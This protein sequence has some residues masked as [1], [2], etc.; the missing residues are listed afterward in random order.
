MVLNLAQCSHGKEGIDYSFPKT[1]DVDY[2]YSK[3]M[4]TFRMGFQWERM[5][6]TLMGEFDQTYFNKLDAV[7]KYANSKNMNVFLNPHNFARY[8][9]NGIEQLVGSAL[10]P[11]AAFAD[12]W[13]RLS[14]KYKD[15]PLVMFS[16]VNE[17]HDM[18]TMQ[19][20]SAANDAIAAIRSTGAKN[21]I[22]VPGNAWTGANQWSSN[23][24][25]NSG[26]DVAN[27]VAMLN[28]KDSQNNYVF[29]VHNY[30]DD[31]GSGNYKNGDCL[32]A[33]AGSKKLENVTAWARTNK[34]KVLVGEFA[35]LDTPTCKSAVDDFLKY[36]T[37]NPDVY[38]GWLWWSAGSSWSSTYKLSLNQKNGVDDPRMSFMTSYLPKVE[39]KDSSVSDASVP[40]SAPPAPT[41]LTTTYDSN[42]FFR[43][44]SGQ[45]P[46]IG[47]KP[48]TY[49]D[50]NPISL[51]VWMHGC[52]GNAE[53]DLWSVAPSATKKTQSYIV[54][55]LG[56]RD[57]ACWKVNED[58]PK[59]LAAIDHVKKYFNIN[60]RKIY[61]GGYSSGGDMTYRVGM[62]N[63]NLFAGLFVENSDIWGA[64]VAQTTLMQQAAWKLNI[65]QLN[66]LSDTTYPIAKSRTNLL[67]LKNAGFQ[68]IAV[69]K[70]GTHFDADTA[71]SG[72]KYNLIKYVLP[73]L[74]AEWM[75]PALDAGAPMDAAV[76][77]SSASVDASLDSGSKDA[78]V[79]ASDAGKDSG[80]FDSGIKD[81]GTD[82]SVVDAGSDA[83]VPSLKLM[84]RITYNWGVGYC[85]EVDLHNKTAAP[86]TWS[87]VRLNLRGAT[88]RDQSNKGKPWD[89]WN[90]VFPDR[91]G[92]ITVKPMTGNK[93]VAA[94]S[95]I[96][97]GFCADMGPLNWTATYVE[98]SLK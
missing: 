85:E 35:V 73:Y 10:V 41:Y 36:V 52:G 82:S 11:N 78:G 3:N 90:A 29:E 20:V 43:L 38:V 44:N 94:N 28:I 80:V 51:F 24:G 58:T 81:A 12:F 64:G 9:L 63:A 32:S 69:E 13:K 14:L 33:T 46:Y 57:G 56:G 7:V 39:V 2:F 61:L 66:H 86:L 65:V 49:K 4:N 71:T 75:L 8:K 83:A 40:D 91:I 18:P 27:S 48:D 88:I 84:I 98:G 67:A 22:S 1:S 89:T 37:A 55:S 21:L 26:Y 45:S 74:D 23:W 59:V 30:F 60:P 53:G 92:V 16:L 87:E 77:D 97:F 25:A 62:Q 42:G 68:V 17:P 54:I 31:D 79:D 19:W 50:T 76:A 15:N 5:Q 96:T 34:K 72:T 6:P 70:P 93:T 47:Y 95:K